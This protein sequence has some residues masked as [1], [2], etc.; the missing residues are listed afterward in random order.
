MG[1]SSRCA[2]VLARVFGKREGGLELR[3]LDSTAPDA[4]RHAA[5][6]FDLRKTLFLVSSKS[7]TTTEVNSFYR[8]Y[9]SRI[10]DGANF[11]AI[12]DGGSPLQKLPEKEGV[13]RAFVTPSDIGGRYS[14]VSVSGLVRAALLGLD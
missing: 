6:G 12:S 2:D 7:G 10:D 8:H 13:W 5:D 11:V 3:V 9:R 1:G 4:V 14:V